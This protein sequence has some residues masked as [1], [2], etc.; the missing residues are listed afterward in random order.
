MMKSLDTVTL[1]LRD[2]TLAC[3]QG[4]PS[5]PH[6]SNPDSRS[7]NSRTHS[8]PIFCHCSGTFPMHN[9]ER[10]ILQNFERGP[11]ET[12]PGICDLRPE[13][14]GL[15]TRARKVLQSVYLT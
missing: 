13:V 12:C 4:S 3:V 5:L 6:V 10:H 8:P 14:T 1:A 7:L 15:L 9:Q 2:F 11:S